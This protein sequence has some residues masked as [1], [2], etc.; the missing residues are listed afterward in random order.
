MNNPAIDN[1]KD[2]V[3][4]L[5]VG[6]GGYGYHYLKTIWEELPSDK[7]Q[8]TGI[9]DPYADKSGL[10]PEVVKRSI[11]VFN[12][13]DE[14]NQTGHRA[15]LTVISSPIHYHV[16][17]SITALE[18]GSCVLCEKPLCGSIQEADLLIKKRDEVRK[19][20]MVGYQWS[21]SKAIQSLKNDILKGSFG[22]PIRMKSLCLWPR[23]DAY[24]RRNDWAGKIR[25]AS[26]RWIL[27][28]PANN[29]MAHYL[30]NLLYLL[31][32]EIHLSAIPHDVTSEA[33][34]VN[35]IENY[36]TIACRIF[37]VEGIELLFY[38]SHAT[39]KT[40]NPVFQLEFEDAV[41]HFSSDQ[42]E[43][44]AVDRKGIR[45]SYGSPDD[46]HQFMKLFRAV[47]MVG[48][49]GIMECGIEAA[50]SHTVCI[51]GIQESALNIDAFPDSLIRRDRAEQR[52]WAEGLD[53]ALYNCYRDSLLP[54]EAGIEWAVKA[55]TCNVK[56][57]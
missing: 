4:M 55:K 36:D 57:Y 19:W 31:G 40:V 23:D 30:H 26:G 50:R 18:N 44:I 10:Y 11:P 43:I 51:N 38:A 15:D 49:T 28:S 53:H 8:V 56:S 34:R 17:Q 54:H 13:V 7:V 48:K 46:D 42:H 12:T 24:Y 41:I 1:L 47:E 27:D 20:V 37:T 33:Y 35:P 21:Y 2:E 29:A 52:W 9:I 22:S 3:S 39:E 5:M 6:I 32:E 14:F 45:K 16:P 25:D